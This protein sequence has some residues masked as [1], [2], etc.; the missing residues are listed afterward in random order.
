M[1][2]SDREPQSRRGSPTRRESSIGSIT[3]S[4]FSPDVQDLRKI[5]VLALSRIER[6]DWRAEIENWPDRHDAVRVEPR[7]TAEVMGLDVGHVHCWAD[8]WRFCRK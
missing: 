1:R 8:F 3:V 7:V 6:T 4:G 2:R 5:Q